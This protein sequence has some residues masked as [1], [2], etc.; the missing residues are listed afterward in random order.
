MR[1]ELSRPGAAVSYE[2]TGSGAPILLGHSLLDS[3]EMWNRIVPRLSERFELINIDVRGHGHSTSYSSFDLYDLA[4]DWLAI[5]DEEGIDRALLCGL[6]MGGMT[7]MR[8]AL[9]A[10]ERVAGLI[11]LDTTADEE[12]RLNRIQYRLMVEIVVRL[13]YLSPIVKIIEKK[14]FSPETLQKRPHLVEEFTDRLA[15]Q[16]PKQLY[17]AVRAVIERASILQ[18][19][20]SIEVPTLIIVGEDDLSTPPGCSVRMDRAF[21]S[22]RLEILPS[23]GHLSVV[24]S[25]D[26]IAHLIETFCDEIGWH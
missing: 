19:L 8:V 1:R 6:S 26:T 24:E 3:T 25:P 16:E 12:T 22:S 17:P 18:L 23:T 20:G 4:D 15:A 9:R 14:F 11:L 21:P 13:G 2:K 10:P 7:A 5:M